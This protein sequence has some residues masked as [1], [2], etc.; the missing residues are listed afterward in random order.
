MAAI[1]KT[2]SNTWKAVI[3]K[4][5]WPTTIKTFRTKRD[6]EDWARGTEDEMVRGVYIN[7]AGAEKLLLEK[8]LDRY[9]AEVSA[10][11]RDNAAQL[12]T[13]SRGWLA[14]EPF[15]GSAVVVTHHAPSSRLV[16]PRY[17]R[18][19]L[20][21]AFASSLE[22]MIDGERAALWVHG[23]MHDAFDYESYGTRIVCNPLGYA[24][25]A[26]NP[27]FRPDYVIEI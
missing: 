15:E 23:H 18:D 24:P 19:Q 20:T 26:L 10:S 5:G 21:P 27:E 6:A 25:N 22:M 11:K 9:L 14:A 4:R 2:P 17:A 8:A 1:T 7:R 3:R 16:H 13:A 12:H